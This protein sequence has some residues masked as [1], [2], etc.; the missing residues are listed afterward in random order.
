MD[1]ELNDELERSRR[2]GE[3]RRRCELASSLP[4][5]PPAIFAEVTN[6]S[7]RKTHRET[8]RLPRVNAR[9]E[10]RSRFK[11]AERNCR[12]PFTSRRVGWH[13]DA[14]DDIMLGPVRRD[15]KPN[16]LSGYRVDWH[17]R[18]T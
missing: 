12:T 6:A 15:S 11:G 3:L 14:N 18:S 16:S 2:I 7:G 17:E 10:M 5:K 1:L 9:N 8:N 4:I 13:A